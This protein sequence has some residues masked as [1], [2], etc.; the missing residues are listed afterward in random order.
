MGR[1]EESDALF[2]S[3]VV[4]RYLS[5]SVFLYY[6]LGVETFGRRPDISFLI[7]LESTLVCLQNTINEAS[8]LAPSTMLPAVEG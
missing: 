3:S 6:G 1:T 8:F 2:S 5:L 7:D 4:A